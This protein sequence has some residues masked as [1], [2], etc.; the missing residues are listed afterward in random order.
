MPATHTANGLYYEVHGA[1]GPVVLIHGSGGN[2]LSWWQQIPDLGKEFCC[3]TFDHRGFGLS[4]DVGRLTH[5]QLTDDLQD[6]LDTLAIDRCALVGQSLGGRTAL[7]FALSEPRRVTKLV[8]AGTVGGIRDPNVQRALDQSGPAPATLF[9]R[10]LSVEFRKNNPGLAFLYQQIE[11]LN[12]ARGLPPIES[13]AGLSAA[14]LAGFRVPAIFLGGAQ[15]PVAPPAA[16][17]AAAGLLPN[18]KVEIVP[19][20]GHS[21]YFEQPASF[22]RVVRAFLKA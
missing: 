9:E 17:V 13:G 12:Q 2:H 6:L 16:T 7:Q 19:E 18:A 20:A 5:E 1:G 4:P 14:A 8:L 15:D 21:V 10:A 11:G 22:N 3:I